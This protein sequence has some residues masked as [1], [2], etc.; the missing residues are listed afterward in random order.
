M[1]S[2]LPSDIH[3]SYEF[4]QSPYV[5]RSIWG[6]ISEGALG[7]V[8]VGLMILLFLRDWRSALIV[9]LNIPLALMAAV[10][11]LWLTGQTINLMTLGGLALAIGILVDEATVA[12]E[13]IH[14]HLQHGQHLALAVRDGSGET[15]IPRL[16]AMVCILAVFISSFFMQGAPRA[17]FVPLSLAVGFSMM[18]SYL[19]SSTL[20]PVLSIWILRHAYVGGSQDAASSAAGIAPQRWRTF[21]LGWLRMASFDHFR[22]GYEWLLA[23]IVHLRWVLVASYLAVS[24][25]IIGLVGSRLGTEIFPTIDTGQFRLRMRRPGRN[26]HRPNRADRPK[27]PQ[28]HPGVCGSGQ[29]TD[30]LGIPRHDSLHLPDQYR[31]SMDARAGGRGDVG[32]L[33]E[34]K[35]NQH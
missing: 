3:I 13:N 14:S 27:S 19:L 4:D 31:V 28:G 10:V 7:A 30:D 16:L 2:V 12:I 11:A 23:K 20:V 9:L 18:A 5:T 24:L 17:M 35:W 33:E 34:R 15:A 29:R 21:P 25:A 1:Q 6:V 26:G 22:R 8:L 32:G